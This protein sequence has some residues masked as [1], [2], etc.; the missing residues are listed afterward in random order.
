MSLSDVPC[1]VGGGEVEPADGKADLA[2]PEEMVRR[3]GQALA[4]HHLGKRAGGLLA[5]GAG[6]DDATGA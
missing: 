6:R 4:D 5:R 2:G 3:L 1:G